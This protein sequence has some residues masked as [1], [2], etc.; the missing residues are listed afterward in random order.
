MWL[1]DSANQLQSY[2]GLL[3]ANSSRSSLASLFRGAINLQAR[4]I[5]NSPYCNAFQA[6]AEAAM[7]GGYG[8]GGDFVTPPLDWN[9]VH[10]CKYEL[11]S[12]AAF[13][14]LSHD[15]YSATGDV[16]FFAR[17]GNGWPQAVDNIL[18]TA[19][20]LL[21]GTYTDDGHVRAAPYTFQRQTSTGSE[22][23]TNSGAGNPVKGGTG[24]VRSAFRPLG[25]LVHLPAVHPGQHDVLALPRRLRRHHAALQRPAGPEDGRLRREHPRRHRAPRPRQARRVRRHLRLRGGRL[26]LPQH[27][28][29]LADEREMEAKQLAFPARLT[30]PARIGRRQHPVPPQRPHAGLREQDGPRLPE[31]AALRPQP[32]QSVLHVWLRHQRVGAV[33]YIYLPCSPVA[34]RSSLC[35]RESLLNSYMNNKRTG[36]P[37][38]G[39][40]MTWP[41]SLIVRILTTDDDDEI[42]ASLQQLLSSTDGLGLI[43]ES[44][45]SHNANRWTRQWWVARHIPKPAW[46][47]SRLTALPSL[48]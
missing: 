33:F 16:A 26:R 4:Y 40:G 14:Q 20:E 6:P 24:L 12:L 15:Y 10:E 21:T 17:P 19:A 2:K 18:A 11:D 8:G 43:H 44:V 29:K 47:L 7:S 37:H 22:T 46:S 45:G 35:Q 3:R 42:V 34:L 1:R 31:H 23:L 39:T 38:V 32:G 13:L 36:G 9:M 5:R 28:G 25:R 30:P 27:H 41:M 48:R